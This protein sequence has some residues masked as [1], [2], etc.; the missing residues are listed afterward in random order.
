M[1]GSSD[2][3]R[4]RV[5]RRVRRAVGPWIDRFVRTLGRPSY[6]ISHTEYVGTVR[7][8]LAD[9][10]SE[11]RTGGFGWAPLSL[12]HRTPLRGQHGRELDV[13]SVT[14][15]RPPAPRGPLLA[16][17]RACRRVR[18]RRVQLVVPPRQTREGARRPP[19]SGRRADA[20][21]ARREGVEYDHES[22]VRRKAAHLLQHARERLSGDDTPLR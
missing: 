1:R 3:H 20:P 5:A 14:V 15:R 11:L 12:Y 17:G 9:L 16:V 10:E 8:S 7:L 22:V 21:L 6:H 2:S 4:R 19:K 18:P 13:P